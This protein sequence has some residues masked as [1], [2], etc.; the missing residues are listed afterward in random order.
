PRQPRASRQRRT[1]AAGT[2]SENASASSNSLNAEAIANELK[3]RPDFPKIRSKILD[4]PGDWINKCRMVAVAAGV[5]ITSGD[6]HRV[7]TV[8]RIKSA[9][10][11]LSRTLSGNASEFLTRGSNPVK[12]EMTAHA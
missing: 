3:S 10:P 7:L 6:V 9:L 5:P 4:V 11:T 2:A 12:Y 1:G 8:L